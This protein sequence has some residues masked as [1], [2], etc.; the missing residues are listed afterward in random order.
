MNIEDEARSSSVYGEEMARLYD[1]FYKDKPY[2]DEANFVVGCLEAH[3]ERD[4]KR[5]LDIACGTGRH[6][7]HVAKCGIEV[8]GL[9]I[10][11]SMIAVA[12]SRGIEGASFQVADML[13]PFPVTGYDAA[14]CLFDSIGYVGT[15]ERVVQAFGQ[16]RNALAPGAVLL[17]EYWHAAAM[18][19][20]FSDVRVGNWSTPDGEVVRV[21]KT[22]LDISAQR[23]IVDFTVYDM[24]KF[25]VQVFT[26]QHINRYFGVSEMEYLAAQGGLIPVRSFAGYNE[27]AS[28]D[29][30]TW[31]VILA[32]RV[33]AES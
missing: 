9:D 11:A 6:S 20:E 3:S 10:S 26:E 14:Y 31:H 25:P 19:R 15:S 22:A 18:L 32:C 2:A 13:N 16:I 33:P 1:L 4:I 28:I 30:K 8:L 12:S 17:V 29:S 5:V 7:A 27:N 21:S 24:R 23:S